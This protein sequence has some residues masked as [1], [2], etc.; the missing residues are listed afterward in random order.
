MMDPDIKS[1]ETTVELVSGSQ[2]NQGF[3]NANFVTDTGKQTVTLEKPFSI[4]S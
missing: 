4:I 1:E 2:I 3:A